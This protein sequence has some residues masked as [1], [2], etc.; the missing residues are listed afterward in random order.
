[1]PKVKDVMKKPVITISQESGVFEAAK[2][3]RENKIGALVVVGREDF[4]AGI[5][6]ETDI[7][8]KVVAEKKPLTAKIKDVMTKDLKTATE[9]EDISQAA[10]VMAAHAIRRLPVVKNRKLVGIITLRDI[11]KAEAV[12][13][14]SDYYPYFT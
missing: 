2:L 7:I 8:Y 4:P 9:D 3:M 1:M 13:K 6:T 14:G 5:L 10:K 12:E 11:V